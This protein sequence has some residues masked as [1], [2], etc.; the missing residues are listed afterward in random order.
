MTILK[1]LSDKEKIALLKHN[2]FLEKQMQKFGFNQDVQNQISKNEGY[3]IYG[4]E[5]T[6][7]TK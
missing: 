4:M 2:A 6:T 1:Q 5:V 7:P 3:I